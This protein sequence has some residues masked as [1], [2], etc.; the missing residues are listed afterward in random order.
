[1]SLEG[2]QMPA[3]KS[4]Y[5]SPKHRHITRFCVILA[6]IFMFVGLVFSALENRLKVQNLQKHVLKLDRSSV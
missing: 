6:P 4:E 1:M 2:S 5:F 3:N